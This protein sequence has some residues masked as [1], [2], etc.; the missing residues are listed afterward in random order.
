MKLRVK[1][2]TSTIKIQLLLAIP[3]CSYTELLS[4][5][6]AY[7]V[8]NYRLYQRSQLNDN[9]QGKTIVQWS[10]HNS[11]STTKML[12]RKSF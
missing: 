10:T 2:T 11:K 7:L 1:K 5:F 12:Q 8:P 4:W 6:T 3:L 9:K